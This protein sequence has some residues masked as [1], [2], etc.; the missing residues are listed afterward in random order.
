MHDRLDAELGTGQSCRVERADT[1]ARED[2]LERDAGPRERATSHP[3][4]PSTPFRER[5]IEVRA[6]A[7]C[8]GVAVAEEPK[9]F[10]ID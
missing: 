9:V 2:E 8:L 1:R 10:A 5:P 7:V 3:R 6:D 4:L